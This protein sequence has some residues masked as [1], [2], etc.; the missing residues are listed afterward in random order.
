MRELIFILFTILLSSCGSNYK[1][2]VT[3]DYGN[4]YLCNTINKVGDECITFKDKPGFS[5]GPGHPTRIC[6]KFRIIKLK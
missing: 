5:N 3:D 6:G 2:R 4:V 1:Y